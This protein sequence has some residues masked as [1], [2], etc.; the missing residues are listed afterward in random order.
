MRVFDEI[1]GEVER[2]ILIALQVY[3]SCA[4]LSPMQIIA[5]DQNFVVNL[6]SKL[7]LYPVEHDWVSNLC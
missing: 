3:A 2:A 5:G 7:C 1:V 4:F 6:F